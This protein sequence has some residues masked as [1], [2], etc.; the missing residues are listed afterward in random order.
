[1]W[2]IQCAIVVFAVAWAS[3][4][5]VVTQAT[6]TTQ[7]RNRETRNPVEGQPDAVRRGSLLYRARCAGCHGLDA[8]G[9]SA[10]DLTA[11]LAS[12]T[13]DER[14]FQ[15]VRRG[16]SGTEMPFFDEEHTT[17]TQVWEVLAHLRTL[18]VGDPLEKARGN[19]E[20]G[21]TVFQANCSSCHMVSGQ[22]GRL[23]PDLSR[24]GAARSPAA[25]ANKIRN[26]SRNILAG[27]LPVTVVTSDGRRVRGL[28][29]NEDP[30]SIQI[31]DLNERLQGYVKSNVNEVIHE[32]R[33]VMPEFG[34]ARLSDDDLNDVVSYLTTL[35]GLQ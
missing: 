21:R 31:M 4:A 11:V 24:I 20:H 30:F 25:L 8:H 3:S 23:G 10:P 32:Q 5:N 33:S 12:G 17:D 35:R 9:V 1:M 29:K 27:Y 26:P 13:S 28:R 6:Q 14:F 34:A 19:P 15:T 22:G 2:W 7:D 18:T 16:V